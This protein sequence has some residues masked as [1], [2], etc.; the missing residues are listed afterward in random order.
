MGFG[1]YYDNKLITIF[2]EKRD[3]VVYKKVMMEPEL[4]GIEIKKLTL[5]IVEN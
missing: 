3:A 4:K 5:T 2:F 1:V